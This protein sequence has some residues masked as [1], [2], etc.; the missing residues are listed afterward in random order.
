ML[1]YLLSL[2]AGYATCLFM[3]AMQYPMYVLS[4]KAGEYHYLI[5]HGLEVVTKFVAVISSVLLWRGAWGLCKD[6]LLTTPLHFWL[7]HGV[8][9]GL[10]FLL[11][12]ASSIASPAIAKECGSASGQFYPVDFFLHLY[13]TRNYTKLSVQV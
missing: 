6:Y 5:E 3:F 10:L 12:S 13:Q 9:I 11:H 7:S 8:G 2:G 1:S 4:K